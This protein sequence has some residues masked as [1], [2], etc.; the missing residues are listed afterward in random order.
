MGV[1]SDG[2]NC[3]EAPGMTIKSWPKDNTKSRQLVIFTFQA[4]DKKKMQ[5]F[6]ELALE[7]YKTA[8]DLDK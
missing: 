5:E 8:L 2:G 3:E 7:H 1:V 4:K 6:Y